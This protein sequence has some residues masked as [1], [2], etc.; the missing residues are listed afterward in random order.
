MFSECRV[1]CLLEM[2]PISISEDVLVADIMRFFHGDGPAQQFEAGQGIITVLV[3]QLRAHEL[4]IW[5]IHS[6]AIV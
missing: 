4:M 6:D 2:T 1:D 5:Q 3:A